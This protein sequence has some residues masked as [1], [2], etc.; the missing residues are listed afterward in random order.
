MQAKNFGALF[1]SSLSPTFYFWWSVDYFPSIFKIHAEYIYF[2]QPSCWYL[3]PI[4]PP[5][6]PPLNY[7]HRLLSDLADSTLT[8]YSCFTARSQNDAPEVKQWALHHWEEKLVFTL[9]SRTLYTPLHALFLFSSLRLTSWLLVL[10]SHLLCPF[11]QHWPLCCPFNTPKHTPVSGLC[12]YHSVSPH[13]TVSRYSHDLL[14]PL[15]ETFPQMSPYQ[16]SFPWSPYIK[17]QISLPKLN[18]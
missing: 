16:W 1:D 12:F 17:W 11:Q 7:F 6:A 18:I 2:S 13:P 8:P 5:A 15:P 14:S 4:W 9:A 3:G 10:T